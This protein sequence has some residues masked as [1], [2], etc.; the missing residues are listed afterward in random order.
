VTRD[1]HIDTLRAYQDKFAKW[2]IERCD[3]H[4]DTPPGMGRAIKHA[5]WMIQEMLQRMEAGEDKPGQADRW[6]GF[7]QGILWCHGMFTIDDMKG[8]NTA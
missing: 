8:H 2:S 6:L 3:P 1:Q 5:N 7:V 4:F